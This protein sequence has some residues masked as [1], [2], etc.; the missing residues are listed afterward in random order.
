M[1]IKI[2]SNAPQVPPIPDKTDLPFS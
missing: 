1:G 2:E